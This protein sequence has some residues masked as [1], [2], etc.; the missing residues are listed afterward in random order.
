MLKYEDKID[1]IERLLERARPKWT[2]SSITWMNF[3]D[4]KQIV[5]I[6]FNEKWW[7]WNQERPFG[8]WAARLI[9]NQIKNQVRNNYTSY[10]R[11]CISA[12]CIHNLGNGFCALTKSG[13]QDSSCD[14][15]KKWTKKLKTKCDI[16]LPVTIEGGVIEHRPSEENYDYGNAESILHSKVMERLEGRHKDIYRMIYIESRSDDYVA[17]FAGF[18]AE[19]NRATKRYKHL[20][21]LKK[22]F[23]KV[24]KEVMQDPD[25]M[26]N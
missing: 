26:E 9:S 20:Q 15:Y 10:S 24:A 1:E 19:K 4:V 5:R 17:D 25:W 21:L 18:K 14:L 23:T 13:E 16:K 22:A 11:P 6:H 7:Q 3:D 2:L 8:P 12:R